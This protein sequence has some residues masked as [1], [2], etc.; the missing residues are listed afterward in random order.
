MNDGVAHCYP[1]CVSCVVE[2]EQYEGK[3]DE[4]IDHHEEDGEYQGVL[5]HGR[6]LL[7][8]R[9]FLENGGHCTRR[10]QIPRRGTDSGMPVYLKSMDAVAVVTTWTYAMG[11][12]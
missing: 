5:N 3:L 1:A 6:T 12:P 8:A 7:P 4:A 2:A 9:A 10:T 11:V